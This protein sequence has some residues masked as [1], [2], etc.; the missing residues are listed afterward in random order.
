MLNPARALA[1][2]RYVAE[3]DGGGL[4]TALGVVV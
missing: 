1:H 4:E 2:W 3:Y